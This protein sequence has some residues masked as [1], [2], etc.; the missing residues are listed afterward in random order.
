MHTFV[1]DMQSFSSIWIF[2][3]EIWWRWAAHVCPGRSGDAKWSSVLRASI[4]EN[5]AANKTAL[6]FGKYVV[7]STDGLHS[8]WSN[9]VIITLIQIWLA[10]TYIV[11]SNSCKT[12]SLGCVAFELRIRKLMAVQSCQGGDSWRLDLSKI[13]TE[14]SHCQRKTKQYIIIVTIMA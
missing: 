5:N 12:F 7:L 9:Y 14:T 10:G 8:N 4:S 6:F 3:I 1:N 11:P 2:N 13:S